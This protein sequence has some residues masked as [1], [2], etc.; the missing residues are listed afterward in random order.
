MHRHVIISPPRD[1]GGSCVLACEI[2]QAQC[3]SRSNASRKAAVSGA[4]VIERSW[5]RIPLSALGA[6]FPYGISL[7]RWSPFFFSPSDLSRGGSS[8]NVKPMTPMKRVLFH[9][10]PLDKPGGSFSLHRNGART[11]NN[12]L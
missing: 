7:D 11:L 5:V 1:R 3:V 4:F 2:R 6:P 10:D 8:L 9:R 12:L